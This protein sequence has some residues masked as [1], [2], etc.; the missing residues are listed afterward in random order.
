MFH[1]YWQAMLVAF[2][3]AAIVFMA[4]PLPLGPSL[5]DQLLA[6]LGLQLAA[7]L[8]ACALVRMRT[9]RP[10]VQFDLF[11]GKKPLRWRHLRLVHARTRED[12]TS[13][14]LADK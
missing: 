2:V 8:L 4:V 13:Q 9:R 7:M 1:R 10:P 11:A 3:A 14:H 5:R 6:L 12:D